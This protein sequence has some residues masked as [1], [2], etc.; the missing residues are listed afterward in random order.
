MRQLFLIASM[1]GLFMYA[2]FALEYESIAAPPAGGRATV[3]LAGL[4]TAL[5]ATGAGLEQVTI[6]GWVRVG[7]PRVR[8]Q[9]AADL[10]WAERAA[11]PGEMR[12]LKVHRRDGVDYLALRWVLTGVASSDWQ[13]GQG[14]VRRALAAVGVN[15]VVTVQLEGTTA[16]PGLQEVGA[17]ALDALGATERQP[18]SDSRS[19]SIAGRTDRLP[20][21]AVG[22]NVQVAV[23]RV[24]GVDRA[25]VWVAWPALLQEY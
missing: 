11:P 6:T 2:G 21:S 18:W 24:S 14:K 20:V 4:E 12:E 9:V 23:R 3:S 16:R 25:K 17:R 5:A 13:S 7:A 22:V 19:A 1:V 8:E 15:P 10:G